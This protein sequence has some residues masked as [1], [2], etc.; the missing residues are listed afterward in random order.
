MDQMA[1]RFL[2]AKQSDA[3]FK[4]G[5]VFLAIAAQAGA[6][7]GERQ[8]ASGAGRKIER[9]CVF[10]RGTQVLS[11]GTLV[12][13]QKT[14]GRK[15]PIL[16]NTFPVVHKMCALRLTARLISF[17]KSIVFP[18]SPIPLIFLGNKIKC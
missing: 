18:Q 17:F 6:L 11:I 14:G 5:R 2:I 3:P 7:D 4:G 1:D 16:Y 9:Q 13:T 10:A 15:Q 12:A 8:A